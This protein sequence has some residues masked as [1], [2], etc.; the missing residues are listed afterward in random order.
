[1]TIG[2]QG[3]FRSVAISGRPR[4]HLTPAAITMAAM[5]VMAAVAVIGGTRRAWPMN[6]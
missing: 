1:M 6:R 4:P 5:I 3:R 2:T